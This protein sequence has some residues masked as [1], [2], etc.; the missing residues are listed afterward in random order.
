MQ[1]V[2]D[3]FVGPAIEILI[4]PALKIESRSVGFAHA[5][6]RKAAIMVGIR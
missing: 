4:G 6:K 3:P 5:K 1:L 2:P